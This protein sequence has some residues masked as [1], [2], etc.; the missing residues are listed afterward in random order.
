MSETI[1][2]TASLPR[3]H[4][5]AVCVICGDLI[6]REQPCVR[7]SDDTP[8]GFI[9]VLIHRRCHA[10]LLVPMPLAAR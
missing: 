3:D 5:D 8:T 7:A 4:D 10:D 1:I 6:R 2:F 9:S